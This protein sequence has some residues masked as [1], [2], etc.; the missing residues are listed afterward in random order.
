MGTIGT[1]ADMA[2]RTRVLLN[3]RLTWCRSGYLRSDHDRQTLLHHFGGVLQGLDG[4][5]RIITVD[6]HGVD[7]LA[8]CSDYRVVL[9]FLLPTPVQLSLTNEPTITGRS[10]C[11]G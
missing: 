8:E 4:G 5:L 11:G 10:C 7:Q 9:K 1:L 6:E 3:G 2:R